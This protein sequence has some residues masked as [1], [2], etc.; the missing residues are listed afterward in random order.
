MITY[1][2]KYNASDEGKSLIL[3]YQRQYSLCL[4][5]IYNRVCEEKLSNSEIERR[6][7][8]LNNISLMNSWFIKCS[9]WE[10]KS[11]KSKGNKVIFGGKKL[12]FDRQKG[13]ITK[14]EYKFKK[15][16]PL[17]SIGEIA[18]KSVK[19]NRFFH[20]EDNLE[21]IT[22]KPNRQTRISL[23]IPKQKGYRLK[24]LAELYKLQEAQLIKIHYKLDTEYIYISFKESDVWK[25]EHKSVA[26][27]VLG[28]D[29]N[30]NYIGW[31]IV[32]W[33]SENEYTVVKSGI[34]SIKQLND[35]DF[36]LKELH[37]ASTDP[38]RKYISNK[39]RFEV[40]EVAK[41]LLN[42]AL[43]YKV[44]TV[45]I[46]DLNIKSKD[47][48]RGTKYNRLVNNMWC[49]N[50]FV[51]NLVKRCNIFGIRLQKV[52]AQYSS[53]VGNF[54][55]RETGLTDPVLSSIEIGRRGYE[56]VNQYITKTKEI[57]KNIIWLDT[58]LFKRQIT[59]SLEEFGLKFDSLDLYK[60]Y[61]YFKNS[62]IKYRV[63]V[64]SDEESV[65]QFRHN[66]SYISH[67]NC[68]VHLC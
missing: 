16:N 28:I 11:L 63:P 2:L 1:K 23:Q 62:E 9:L 49:R 60:I 39:R 36:A 66:K 50:D 64:T 19:S 3:N 12:F 57:K 31:S 5:W 22:F 29:L 34:Y 35:K 65:Y 26:N 17:Y 61:S 68:K 59:K 40:L 4:H 55:Y 38:K 37:V 20:I 6:C 43:Y 14:E 52:Q 32:D 13:I 21:S 54:V 46:E 8:Q 56:F 7:K 67:M 24:T 44:Q 58:E 53:F 41:N 45:T 48:N 27:R 25:H 51:N 42:K 18:V 10:A 15:L 30:P 33:K 47:I